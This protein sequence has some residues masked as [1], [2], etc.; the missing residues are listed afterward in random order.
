M[1]IITQGV[2]VARG[3]GGRRGDERKRARIRRKRGRGGWPREM[4]SLR[5]SEAL[6]ITIGIVLASRVALGRPPVPLGY[7]E[8]RRR[9][10]LRRRALD[11]TIAAARGMQRHHVDPWRR[12][13]ELDRVR[14]W[15]L[16]PPWWSTPEGRARW[17]A[18][19]RARKLARRNPAA[20]LEAFATAC[21]YPAPWGPEVAAAHLRY[22]QGEP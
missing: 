15:Q 2:A 3:V 9:A 13:C 4:P 22:L 20:A 21:G 10:K 17:L 5:R 8:R 7:R 11:R 18:R 16:A 19:D 1:R 14:S 6:V 12:A